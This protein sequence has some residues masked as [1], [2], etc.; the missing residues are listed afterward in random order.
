MLAQQGQAAKLTM[1]NQGFPSVEFNPELYN[2]QKSFVHN[3]CAVCVTMTKM[4][5]VFGC[6]MLVE[7][8][9]INTGKR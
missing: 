9:C 1:M 8:G 3:G 2:F 4:M 6:S 5:K 7:E